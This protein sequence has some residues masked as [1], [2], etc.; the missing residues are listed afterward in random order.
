MNTALGSH[1]IQW[2]A[3]AGIILPPIAGIL[4]KEQWRPGDD[5]Y[6]GFVNSI[7]FGFSCIGAAFLVAWLDQSNW[8]WA[9]WR[10][11]LITITFAGIAMYKLYWKPSAA[12]DVARSLPPFSSGPLPSAPPVPPVTTH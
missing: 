10:Q 5:R 4:Q 8:N 7:I 12:I 9:N 6:N 1:A 2:A 3:L 11:T